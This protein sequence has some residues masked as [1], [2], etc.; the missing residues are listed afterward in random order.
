MKGQGLDHK[1]GKLSIAQKCQGFNNVSFIPQV[2]QLWRPIYIEP[3]AGMGSDLGNATQCYAGHGG[4]LVVR[5][6]G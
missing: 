5:R 3:I 2:V 6:D 4:G 1:K